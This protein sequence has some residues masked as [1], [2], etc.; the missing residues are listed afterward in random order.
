[1]LL[2]DEERKQFATL[3]NAVIDL[4]LVS[5]ELE[6]TIFEHAIAMIDAALED[7][8]PVIFHNLMRQ[9]EQGIDK[10]QAKD[11][12]DRLVVTV[13]QKVDLPYLNEEQEAQLLRIVITPLV[14]AMTD[15]KTLQS[16]LP[17]LQSAGNT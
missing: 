10:D 16:V 2:T 12:A 8:L 7:A 6:Q 4:P 17:A 14:K 11:F 9:I 13:N 3:V 5:E 15:G 1:M